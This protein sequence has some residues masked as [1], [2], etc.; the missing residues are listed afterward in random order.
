MWTRG[1]PYI[2]FPDLEYMGYV[3]N[4]A[5]SSNANYS[6]RSTTSQTQRQLKSTGTFIPQWTFSRYNID[7][8]SGI[9]I[10][11]KSKN[12]EVTLGPGYEHNFVF[13]KSCYLLM[14]AAISA[15]YEGTKLT[16]RFPTG[17]IVTKQ[18]N[19]I[20]RLAAKVGLGYNGEKYFGGLYSSVASAEYEQ[21]N[22]TV[23]NFHTRVFYQP[24]FWCSSACSG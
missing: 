13:R 18:R 6:V 12:T 10:T 11:Q 2:Q 14:G 9:G 16:T 3:I 23:A 20:V 1:D 21:E 15:G 7:D 17:D 22:S 24:I 5:Y 8:K 4:L 19:S